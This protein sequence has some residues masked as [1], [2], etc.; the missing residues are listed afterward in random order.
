MDIDDIYTKLSWLKDERKPGGKLQRKLEDYTEMFE[1]HKRFTNPKRMLVYGRP[2]I[3]KSTFSQKIAVD[4]ASRKNKTLKRF[5][6]LLL[7]KLRDVCEFQDFPSILK[8]SELLARDSSISIDSLH[9]Y[10]LQNQNKVL[11]V[12]DGFDEYNAES[13]SPIR[14]IWE[15]N[16][17]RDCHVVVTTRQMEGEE[18]IKSSHVQCE[19]RGLDSK[20]QV[21]EFACKFITDQREIGEFDRYLDSRDLWEIAEIPLLLLML[22]LVW[23]GRHRKALPKSKLELHERFVETLLLHMTTKNAMDPRNEPSY[24]ILHDYREHLTE[25]GK[26]ALDG[27]L[28]NVLYIDLKNANLHRS[29]FTDKMTRSGLFQVSKLTSGEPNEGL[30]FLHK[31]IQEFLAAWYIM[32]EAV[33][34][35]GKVDC[36]ASIDSLQNALHLKEIL[37]FMCEWSEEGAKAVF[38][39][40]KFIG[41][42][43]ELT[44]CR[45]TKTPSVDDL[46]SEQKTFRYLNLD[47]LFS[48][49]AS[50]KQLVYPTF[51]SSVGGVV[52]VK[53]RFD[54]VQ[55]LASDNQLLSTAL[56]SCVF[57]D[58]S[59]YFADVSPIL[60]ALHAVIVTC[61]GLRF[62]ASIIFR[63]HRIYRF[64]ELT[65]FLKKE[66]ETIYLYFNRIYLPYKASRSE[67]LDVLRELLTASP[68]SQ[69]KQSDGDNS[70][71]LNATEDTGDTSGNCLSLISGIYWTRNNTSEELSVLSDVLS[72]VAFPQSVDVGQDYYRLFD[73]QVVKNMVSHINITDNLSILKLERLN[74]TADDAAVIARSLQCAPKL[75]KLELSV[76]PLHGSVRYLADSL[77][78]VPQLYHLTLST[79]GIDYKECES[80]VTSLKHVP[81]L[82]MLNLSLN[83]LGN[84]IIKLADNLKCVPH[85]T[86]LSLYHTNMGEEEATA[87]AQALKYLPELDELHLGKN[88]LGRG[89][90]VLVQHLSSLPKLRNLN[91]QHVSMT[92]KELDDV[93]NANHGNLITTSYHVSSCFYSVGLFVLVD[94]SACNLLVFFVRWGAWSKFRLKL[95]LGGS[96][97]E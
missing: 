85:L 54:V 33:L 83:S 34:K 12:L 13:S 20:K 14:E 17:L 40:L 29:S 27:L 42:K 19:I 32:N 58:V 91:L 3:G 23:M 75:Y 82:E 37:K 77:R 56:P 43:N 47:C 36:F 50:A 76:I 38:S 35:D 73:A 81:K 89:V 10:V 24:N 84:G 80:L 49:S 9:E 21:N 4:W 51:L 94:I 30:F 28:R 68:E 46:S 78:H 86:Y 72:A 71:C 65:F 1:G 67:F 8:A 62:D 5:D 70:N 22:C 48:C 31:S 16:Q 39:L 87:L 6:L 66:G 96:L 15:G 57:F 63:K 92:K 25:I 26:L 45:F 2:G 79:V 41:E 95:F 53:T 74:M 93:T 64:P 52:L 69:R 60:D 97:S 90:S 7:I 55:E 88:P 44:E 11:L 61:S 59:D 18:L